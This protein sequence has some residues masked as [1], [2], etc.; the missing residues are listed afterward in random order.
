MSKYDVIVIGGG[1]G[2]LCNAAI[3]AKNKKKVLLLEKTGQVGGRAISV[4]YKG[5]KL[6]LGWHQIEDTGSGITKVFNYVGKALRQSPVS[7]SIPLY[8][9]GKW[10]SIQDLLARD[11]A[12]FKK[13][14]KE[15]VED[16][17]WEDIDRLD[18]QPIRPWIRKRT[19]SE[20]ILTLFEVMAIW[21][22]VTLNWWDHSLSESLFMRKLH[23]T[24][25]QMAGYG[26]SPIDGWE[27]I[28]NYLADA[29]RENGGEI[30][31]NTPSLDILIENGRV[32]G[33][34]VQTRMPFMATDYPES[35]IIEAPCIV[36]TLPC[37]DVLDIV[38]E[39]LLPSWYV[40]QIK[41]M[42]RNEL[43][44]LWLGVYAGLPGAMSVLYEREMPGW[45]Q[46]P[47]TGLVGICTDFTAFDPQ[48]SPPG[49]HLVTAMVCIEYNQI[50]TRR[51]VNHIFAEFEK[52][53]EDLF[54]IFKKR[55]WTERH[56]VFKPTYSTQ[57]K[58]GAV[59]RYKPDVEVPAVEGLYFAGD[60]FR[61]RSV[62]VDRP[63][64]IAMTVTEKI[65][66]HPIPEFKN[67]W[68]Y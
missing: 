27:N 60:T 30:R 2:G 64:R 28:W 45:F 43:R 44:C 4:S 29:I 36:S 37:W 58:P 6:N 54:P 47:R 8:I 48:V 10:Q 9:N 49:E 11:K 51:L 23:F 5:Y 14:V 67:S 63:A 1:P 55:L 35:E 25:R 39:A 19:Q 22:G 52:E 59:G 40:D 16:L 12:D 24:E 26:F 41:F 68:H 13:V 21:E 66:G 46:G 50:R 3:L 15:I 20:G 31:L 7:Q 65:L 42:A 56:V 33:V 61:G 18:D 62:G 57:W 17:S 34:E 38:D 53:V 32:V